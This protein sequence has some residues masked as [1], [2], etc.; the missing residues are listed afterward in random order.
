MYDAFGSTIG[1]VYG[2]SILCGFRRS[3]ICLAANSWYVLPIPEFRVWGRLI[4]GLLTRDISVYD[5]T[6]IGSTTPGCQS[7]DQIEW[8][9]NNGQLLSGSAFLYNFVPAPNS[10]PTP[11]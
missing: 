9:Y 6:T 1:K 7:Y 2:E 10:L 5:G 4:V 3:N 8:T 11:F